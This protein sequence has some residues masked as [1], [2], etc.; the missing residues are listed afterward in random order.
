MTNLAMSP[1]IVCAITV[2]SA[3]Q[4]S[5]HRIMSQNQSTR[6]R[7]RHSRTHN[8]LTS[9]SAASAHYHG[10]VRQ[11][12]GQNE[13]V[14]VV[15][16]LADEVDSARAERRGLGVAAE[17]AP[18]LGHRRLN[19]RPRHYCYFHGWPRMF[20]RNENKQSTEARVWTHLPEGN[21]A[22]IL[23]SRAERNSFFDFA[24]VVLRV[25]A[26]KVRGCC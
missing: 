26:G 16:V 11:R 12:E 18:V 6:D 23:K 25:L 13:A 2:D 24:A 21:A 3:P 5:I 14:V 10:S 9:R 20:R 1:S 22:K 7:N 15:R 8:C 19:V 4:R 17:A